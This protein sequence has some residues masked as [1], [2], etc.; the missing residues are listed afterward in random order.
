MAKFDKYFLMNEQ[1][2]LEYVQEKYSFFDKN[3]KLS[4]VEIGDGNLNYV[5]RVKDENTGKSII[6]KHSGIETRAHSGRHVDTDRNRIEA[7]ILLK[8]NKLA[9]GLVPVVYGYDPIMCCMCMEDLKDY[10]IMR[11]GL[12]DEKVYPFFA[13]QVTTYLVDVVLPTTDIVLDHK[14]KKQNVKAFIN[15]DLCNITEQLVYSEAVGNFSGKNSVSY[16]SVD[17]VQKE[18]YEDMSLRLE[19][20]KLKF[21]FMEHAQGLLHGDIHSGSIFI[22]DTGMKAFDVEFAFYGPIGYDLGNVLAHLVFALGHSEA[23]K[24]DPIHKKEFRKWILRSIEDIITLYKSKFIEM[25]NKLAT[26]DLAKTPGF[27]QYYLDGIIIDTAGAMGTE[28][29]RRVVGAA[30]VKDITSIVDQAKRAQLEQKLI[31]IAK[32]LIMH[33]TKFVNGQDFVNAVTIQF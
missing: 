21:S 3:V 15:P 2:V 8:H 30:K 11:T 31:L 23:T 24:G 32:D 33:R 19:V 6:L 22:N 29:L 18:V 9:P 13:D 12:L 28:L 4:C 17:F 27:C 25:Y 26:D 10:T 16:E 7:E 20:A 1:D 14:T 5:F